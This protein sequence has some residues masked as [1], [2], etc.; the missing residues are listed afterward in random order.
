MSAPPCRFPMFFMSAISDSM[1]L[2]RPRAEEGARS[3]RR[4]GEAARTCREQ[5]VVVAHEAGD[6]RSERDHARPGQRRQ[7][8]DGVGSLLDGQDRPSA[9]TRRPSAS[10]LSTSM[11][12][13]LRIVSTSPGLTALPPGMFSVIGAK[14]MTRTPM[15][16][17]RQ[18]PDVGEDG[19]RAA[20]VGLHRH[21]PLEGLEGE[22]TGVEGD[23]LPD[24]H[25]GRDARRRPSA[26]P[27]LVDGS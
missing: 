21:H 6:L 7:V 17:A 20:H 27:P 9:S 2:G 3:A 13:P 14:P 10:V 25:D 5:T 19:R 26:G 1:W 4:P 8:D 22:A 15:P 11:V 16:R 24:E 18:A 23:P 12:F